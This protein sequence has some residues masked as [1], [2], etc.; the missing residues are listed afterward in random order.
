[1]LSEY[2]GLDRCLPQWRHPAR[3]RALNLMLLALV[4]LPSSLWAQTGGPLPHVNYLLDARQPPGMVAR[5]Q[6][7]RIPATAGSF[8]ALSIIGPEGLQ[9]ALAQAGQFLPSLDVP[10]TT[11]MMVGAVYRFRVTRIP[12]QP[13]QELYPTV[14]VIDRLYAPPGREHR[15]PIPVV[16]TEEDLRSAIHGALVTRVIYLEDNEIAEPMAYSPNTQPTMDVGPLDNALQV[17]DRLG[18]P[19]AILRIGSRVPGNL[20][21]DLTSFLYG[22]PPWIPLPTAPDREQFIRD[23]NWNEVVPREPVTEPYSETPTQDY[24]RT[25]IAP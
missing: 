19:V 24:P 18:R 12:F 17:A 5:A 9:V 10:V 23:G 7:S 15:F 2:A 6:S 1:M 4:A 16:L 22:C 25:P 21:G 8:Q 13:G 14:E 3:L 20:Q 11:A